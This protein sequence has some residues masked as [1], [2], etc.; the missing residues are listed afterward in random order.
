MIDLVDQFTESL[1]ALPA[2]NFGWLEAGICIFSPV[3]GFRPS[4]ALR[5]A[6]L[7][8]P[9]PTNLTSVPDFKESVIESK[10]QSTAL[11]ASVLD[12]SV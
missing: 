3:R 7:N 2:L 1:S 11:A 6:T 12:K 8:V 5:R 4:E 9:N 10:T